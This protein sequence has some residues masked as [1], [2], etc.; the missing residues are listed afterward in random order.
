MRWGSGIITEVTESGESQSVSRSVISDSLRPHGPRLLG[1]SVHGILQARTLQWVN[2]PFSRASSQPGIEP[3]SPV[4]QADC[5]PSEPPRNPYNQG[6]RGRREE[7]RKKG[8]REERRQKEERI[9]RTQI[10]HL[11]RLASLKF[12]GQAGRLVIQVSYIAVLSLKAENLGRISMLQFGGRIPFFKNSVQL[13]RSVVSN[14]LRP[15]EPQ[16]ARL[17]RPSPTPRVHPNP[18]PSSP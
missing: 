15:H 13:S 8:G 11:Q 16:H 6:E 7:E 1:S 17:P 18:C 4:L 2:I 9:L 5:L 3:S 10:M 14:S 12:I